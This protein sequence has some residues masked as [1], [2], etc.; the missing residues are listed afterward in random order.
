MTTHCSDP[1]Q[2]IGV[3]CTGGTTQAPWSGETQKCPHLHQSKGLTPRGPRG[4]KP[5]VPREGDLLPDAQQLRDPSCRRGGPW[6]LKGLNP[7]EEGN[8]KAEDNVQ[9]T[10][11][12]PGL[13]A[14]GGTGTGSE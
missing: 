13:T 5:T 7:K 3:A 9:L 8:R 6:W 2:R 4:G 14:T 1:T 11:T 12:T 10:L